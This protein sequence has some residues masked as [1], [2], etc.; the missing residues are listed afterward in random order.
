VKRVPGITLLAPL[1]N[2]RTGFAEIAKVMLPSVFAS[3][4]LRF[5]SI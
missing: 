2:G 1:S 5:A 4:G 3:G